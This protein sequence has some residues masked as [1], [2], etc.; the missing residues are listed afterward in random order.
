VRHGIELLKPALQT[1]FSPK[2]KEARKDHPGN[3]AIFISWLSTKECEDSVSEDVRLLIKD[4]KN[5][6]KKGA[7]EE[8]A[9]PFTIERI[10]KKADEAKDYQLQRVEKSGNAKKKARQSRK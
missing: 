8:V 5:F 10:Y 6:M 3:V 2:K 9:R 1:Y 4:F 7:H